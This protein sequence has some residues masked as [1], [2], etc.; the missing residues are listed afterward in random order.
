MTNTTK[1]PAILPNYSEEKL[2][3]FV[4]DVD[5]TLACTAH[6]AHLL[7]GD[8]K[9]WHSFHSLCVLDAPI[10]SVVSVLT[11]LS[12]NHTIILLTGRNEKYRAATDGWLKINN[13]DF[14]D[15]LLM[16]ED[17]DFRPDWQMK[18]DVFDEIE[19]KFEILGAF[20]DNKDV[21]RMLNVRSIRT[22]DC[23]QK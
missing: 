2:Q 19:S 3:C 4:F 7:E 6:R 17:E 9:D 20:D 16:R 18:S 1:I 11:A 13:L 21:L 8:K 10:K 15:C 5:N 14:V 12:W 22:F 23:S